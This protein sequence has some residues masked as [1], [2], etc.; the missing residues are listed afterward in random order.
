MSSKNLTLELQVYLVSV[1]NSL[2][3]MLFES[4]DMVNTYWKTDVSTVLGALESGDCVGVNARI[5]KAQMLSGL[6]LC[7][8]FSNLF[9]NGDVAQ[10]DY[11]ATCQALK[12]GNGTLENP[13][14]VATEN[15]A[16]RMKQ[17]GTD[18]IEIHKMAMYLSAYYSENQIQT[19]C[20]VLDAHRVVFG[21]EMTKTDLCGSMNMLAQLQKFVSNQAP[22]KGN[23][24]AIL[25]ALK[26]YS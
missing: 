7:E 23:Y 8:Q 17:F 1:G 12:Y 10:A 5:T 21:C 6:S 13:R 19:V 3:N 18:V 24:V 2:C 11:S 15:L 16:D 25:Q 4:I 20:D 9:M 22:T 14:S 26:R